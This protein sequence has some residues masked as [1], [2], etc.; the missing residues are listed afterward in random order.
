MSGSTADATEWE[1]ID[2][3][4]A[5]CKVKVGDP[6]TCSSNIKSVESD[7]PMKTIKQEETYGALELGMKMESATVQQRLFI[8]LSWV[9]SIPLTHSGEDV[10]GH[11]RSAAT[12]LDLFF[13]RFLPDSFRFF[14]IFFEI[15]QCICFTLLCLANEE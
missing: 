1:I 7:K 15:N 5:N 2:C 9:S 8:S 3:P 4:C 10:N 13:P 12:L 11:W 6:N 14:N